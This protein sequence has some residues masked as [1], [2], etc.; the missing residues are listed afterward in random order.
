MKARRSG[1]LITEGTFIFNG[2]WV[3][4]LIARRLGKYS[5]SSESQILNQL[6]DYA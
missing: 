5:I 1:D 6:M 3:F 2:I 4:F